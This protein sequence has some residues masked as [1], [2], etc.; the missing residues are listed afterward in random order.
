MDAVDRILK[1]WCIARPDLDV[2]PM[3][4]IGRLSRVAHGLS[5]SMATTFAHHGLN[6]AGFDL[7]ATLRRSPRPHALPAG[8][9]MSSMMITSGTMTN[10]IDQLVK[11]GLVERRADPDD[12]R[13]A[14][15]TLTPQGFDLIDKAIADHVLTQK[16][17][18]AD[19]NES[20]VKQLDTLLRKLMASIDT[21]ESPR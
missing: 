2:G 7:L 6:A 8:E 21:G 16:R 9:L 5:R 18:L 15:V 4:P 12:A 17:L 13:R 14:V 19:M 3:G 20:E 1:Q 11:A 10:R